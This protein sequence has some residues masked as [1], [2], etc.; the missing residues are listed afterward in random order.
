MTLNQKKNQTQR[1][2]LQQ[3]EEGHNKFRVLYISDFIHFKLDESSVVG[4][5][6][7]SKGGNR[8]YK[9]ENKPQLSIIN[10]TFF[11]NAKKQQQKLVLTNYYY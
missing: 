8:R 9:A 11:L 7:I 3:D 6:A 1:I 10:A 2:K 4:R 5:R